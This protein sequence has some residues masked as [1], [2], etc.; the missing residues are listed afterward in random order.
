MAEKSEPVG[1]RIHLGKLKRPPIP[2]GPPAHIPPAPWFSQHRA[3]RPGPSGSHPP[4]GRPARPG[5]GR[6]SSRTFPGRPCSG[7]R[8][9]R[10]GAGSSGVETFRLP[11]RLPLRAR[12][13]V[14][15]DGQGK[16]SHPGPGLL[17]SRAEGHADAS[18]SGDLH[19]GD[20]QGMSFA[21]AFHGGKYGAGRVDRQGKSAGVDG[22][23][24][25]EDQPT[26][27][28]QEPPSSLTNPAEPW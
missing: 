25:S 22:S 21:C 7:G 3:G 6:R 2:S 15:R 9:D 5:D 28:V 1:S 12:Q 8:S 18:A 11:S 17:F 24:L 4:E 16:V 26:R 19:G 13:A 14:V 23:D 10:P 20:D 27:D